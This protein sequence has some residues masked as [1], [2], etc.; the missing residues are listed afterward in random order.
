MQ[1]PDTVS[2]CLYTNKGIKGNQKQ[3]AVDLNDEILILHKK[4]PI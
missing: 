4:C 2:L 3:I 1:I